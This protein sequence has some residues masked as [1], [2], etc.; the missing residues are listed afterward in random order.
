MKG[1]HFFNKNE[2]KEKKYNREK[3]FEL[4]FNK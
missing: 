3:N 1:G 2:K 4:N